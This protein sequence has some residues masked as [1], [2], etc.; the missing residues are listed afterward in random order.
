MAEPLRILQLYPK[1]DYFTGAAIQL[2][3]LVLG[4]KGR[5]HDVTVATRRSEI[6][7]EKMR[8]AAVPYVPLAMASE[9]DLRSVKGLVRILRARP[10]QVIHVEPQP[11]LQF[12]LSGHGPDLGQIVFAGVVASVTDY[13]QHFLVSIALL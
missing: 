7:I 12:R 2:Q 9:V 10:V 3:E 1:E 13:D 8:A 6:W 4:L 11:C 5:G